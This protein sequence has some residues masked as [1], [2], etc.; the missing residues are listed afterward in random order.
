MKRKRG[1]VG[2][3]RAIDPEPDHP[4]GGGRRKGVPFT[5]PPLA[6]RPKRF[7]PKGTRPHRPKGRGRERGRGAGEKSPRPD[8][9]PRGAA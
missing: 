5:R 9:R 8:R 2:L 1:G 6:P 4:R 3:E 7:A